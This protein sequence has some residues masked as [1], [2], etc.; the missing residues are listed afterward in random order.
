MKNQRKQLVLLLL[1]VFIFLCFHSCATL[2]Q[3]GD[4]LM[5]LKR[6]QFKLGGVNNFSLAGIRIGQ[7]SSV[8]DFSPSDGFK[9]LNAFRNNSLPAEIVLEVLALNPND[10]TGG[11]SQTVT[12]LSSLESRLLI[13]GEPTVTGNIDQPIQIPGTG[14]AASI[15]IR[16]TLDLLNFFG[17]KGYEDIIGLALAIG[18]K[19][20]STSRLSLDAL[21]RVSTPYGEIE[22]PERIMIVDKEFR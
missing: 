16:M 9:L 8:S 10:G 21:P 5:N 6:L 14:Q 18:G 2:Q 13:D 3:I 15:P 11:S 7:F 12:T 20:G 1:I 4:A 17:S 22:Y 19:Q